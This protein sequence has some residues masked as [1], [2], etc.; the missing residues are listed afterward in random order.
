MNCS[1]CGHINKPNAVFCGN[2]GSKMNL[3]QKPAA[4]RSYMGIESNSVAN[5]TIISSPVAEIMNTNSSELMIGRAN[6]C[7]LVLNDPGVSSKH[8]KI[9]VDNE[10]LYIEDLK[11]LNG[12]YVDGRKISGRVKVNAF[13]RI[14][15]G[16]YPLNLAHPAIA[17]LVNNYGV[18]IYSDSGV[19]SL[20][21]SQTWVGK[22]LY[23]IMIITFFL[24]WIIIKDDIRVFNLSA[25][26]F[27]FNKLPINSVDEGSLSTIILIL[28]VLLVIG[29]IM[30]F[31]KLKISD[32]LNW[33]NMVSIVIFVATCFY[34]YNVSSQDDYLFE[35][36]KGIKSITNTFGSYLFTFVCFVSIFEGLIEYYIRSNK[37]NY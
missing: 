36:H 11:S 4:T 27:A 2:C 29:L 37:N 28:F 13:S 30:S 8:A 3:L 19:L 15:I 26:D 10:E 6:N 33:A 7:D 17:N 32:K 24:P 16:N 34:L 9:L 14:N 23:F 31:L 5:K 1:K 25:L 21:M 22:I 35:T 12:T 18:S 20:K